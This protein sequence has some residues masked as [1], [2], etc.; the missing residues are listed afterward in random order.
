[1][2]L[3]AG[4][5]SS[6]QTAVSPPWA[7]ASITRNMGV[8]ARV[9]KECQKTRAR[10]KMSNKKSQRWNNEIRMKGKYEDKRYLLGSSP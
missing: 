7:E 1:M 5:Q 2:V 9:K 6:P 4:N 8:C 10:V 3:V